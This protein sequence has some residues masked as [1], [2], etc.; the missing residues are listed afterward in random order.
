VLGVSPERVAIVNNPALPD[1]M[2]KHWDAN[3]VAALVREYVAANR[4]DAVFTFDEGGV[5][6]HPNHV[7][8]AQGVALFA[9]GVGSSRHAEAGHAADPVPC[10]ALET[11]PVYR[12]FIGALDVL[13]S[14]AVH[15][16]RGGSSS[17]ALASSSSSSSS[18][19]SSSSSSSGTAPWPTHLLVCGG[20]RTLTTAHA[21]MVAHASQY[22]WF[23]RIYI[24]FSR[25]P[26]VNTLRRL[27]PMAPS[28]SRL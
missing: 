3:I 21:A 11:V 12:K 6:G 8:V 24:V 2:D 27:G 1:G 25:Y 14:R 20:M 10:Y 7:G 19:L 22:V 16:M 9:G 4:I 5:S 17:P 28:T 18:S 13:V 26:L 23:R 15:T